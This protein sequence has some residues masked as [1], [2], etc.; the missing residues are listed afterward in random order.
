ALGMGMAKGAPEAKET[1]AFYD[2]LLTE[3]A[4]GM[5][6]RAYFRPVVPGMIPADIKDRFPTIDKLVSYDQVHAAKVAKGLKEAFAEIVEQGADQ[7]TVL[8]KK[9]LLK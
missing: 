7:D 4:Q 1:K 5:I 9:N 8:R 3:E 6:A 2:W